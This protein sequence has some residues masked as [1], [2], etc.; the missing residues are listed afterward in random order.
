MVSI[1]SAKLIQERTIRF[2]LN[3]SDWDC[4]E[5]PQLYKKLDEHLQKEYDIIPDKE[6][7]GKG[8]VYIAKYV[9]KAT[10]IYLDTNSKQ[11]TRYYIAFSER[12]FEQGEKLKSSL[13]KHFSLLVL[14]EI[15]SSYPKCFEEYIPLI[16]RW[17]LH[18]DWIV[19]ETIGHSIRAVLKKIPKKTMKFLKDPSKSTEENLRRLA[20]E[21]LRPLADIK[22]LRDPTKNHIQFSKLI[23]LTKYTPEKMRNLMKMWI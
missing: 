10:F 17:A 1:S 20:S 21:S 23:R 5:N 3:I 9:A 11:K 15:I 16:K 18:E 4:L 6:R 8:T 19:R 2:C 12:S 13:L 7:V 14:S 22:W